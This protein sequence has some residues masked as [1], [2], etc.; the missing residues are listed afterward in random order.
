MCLEKAASHLAEACPSHICDHTLCM[1]QFEAKLSEKGARLRQMQTSCA[2]ARFCQFCC[3]CNVLCCALLWNL[4]A[5]ELCCAVLCFA[6][7]CSGLCMQHSVNVVDRCTSRTKEAGKQ[8]T[9]WSF[10]TLPRKTTT[11]SLRQKASSPVL[12][13]RA[14]CFSPR[15]K[16]LATK[17]SA[18]MPG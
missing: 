14:C 16:G 10:W 1:K 7:S 13:M 4:H 2:S 5:A 11:P 15:L 8:L 3:C 12:Y 17:R 6:V 9:C 18:V